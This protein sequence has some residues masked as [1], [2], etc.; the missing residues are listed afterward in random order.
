VGAGYLTTE[1]YALA[2][3]H[4]DEDFRLAVDQA[5]SHI[6]RS[7]K[8]DRIYAHNFGDQTKPNTLL[9]SLFLSTGLPDLGIGGREVR[10]DCRPGCDTSDL[11]LDSC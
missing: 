6:Y 7:G 3:F 10:L 2:L 9:K 11:R 8:I 1:P 5:L 4:G